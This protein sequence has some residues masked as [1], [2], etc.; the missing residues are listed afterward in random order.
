MQ[1]T[2]S[3]KKKVLIINDNWG[4]LFAMQKALELKNY[5]VQTADSFAGMETIIN[6]PPNLI[7][8]DVNLLKE[9]GRTVSQELKGHAAT[10]NIPIIILTGYSNGEELRA[11]AGADDHI[12]KPFELAHL[13]EMTAKYT[14]R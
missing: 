13:W 14:T 5:T 1:H 11:E 8:L 7:F 2:I 10:K 6:D 12:L 4:I 3:H 9:D